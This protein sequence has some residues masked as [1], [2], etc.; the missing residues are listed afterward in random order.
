MEAPPFCND[1]TQ[2]EFLVG[3]RGIFP[4][5]DGSLTSATDFENSGVRGVDLSAPT[6]GHAP[7]DLR[8]PKASGKKPFKY[9]CLVHPFMNGSVV[10]K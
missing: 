9:I 6:A 4:Q 3:A 1:P 10:V 8:F 2:L 7:Y 5:G